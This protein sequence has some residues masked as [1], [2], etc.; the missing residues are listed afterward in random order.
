MRVRLEGH[1]MKKKG[2][3]RDADVLL[4]SSKKLSHRFRALGHAYAIHKVD[5]GLAE[6]GGV[7]G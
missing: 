1:A 3:R 6:H 2:W 5:Y 4:L 7:V